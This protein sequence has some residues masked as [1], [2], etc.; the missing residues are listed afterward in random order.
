MSQPGRVSKSR[1]GVGGGPATVQGRKNQIA[2]RLTFGVKSNAPVLAGIEDQ[3]E[4][5]NF[6]QGYW[7]I[8]QPVGIHEQESVDEIASEYWTLRRIRRWIAATTLTQLY[9]LASSEPEEVRR[10]ITRLLGEPVI[11]QNVFGELE[12][13]DGSNSELAPAHLLRGNGE[14]DFSPS[15][16]WW[17]K[18]INSADSTPLTHTEASWLLKLVLEQVLPSCAQ[19]DE[20]PNNDMDGVVRDE[21]AF[22][23]PPGKITL[24]DLR[25][26]LAQIGSDSGQDDVPPVEEI[27]ARGYQDAQAE[28]HSRE[29]ARVRARRFISE[30]IL[31]S[32]NR[33]NT[34]LV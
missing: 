15:V 21:P 34:A 26:Q 13:G 28:A 2:S 27:L 4:W 22:T 9:E 7:A 20:D 6:R 3:L 32:E 30:H 17:R 24:G 11:R 29:L 16:H 14:E 1:Q 18:I 25:K 31:L 23:L 19:E 12:N 8:W 10:E 5:E 33:I